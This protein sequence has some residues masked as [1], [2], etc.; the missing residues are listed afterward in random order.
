MQSTGSSELTPRSNRV[1][2]SSANQSDGS[3][4]TTGTGG[5]SGFKSM[6]ARKATVSGRQRRGSEAT[7]MRSNRRAPDE[8]FGPLAEGPAVGEAPVGWPST[9]NRQQSDRSRHGQP[10]VP[11][12]VSTYRCDTVLTAAGTAC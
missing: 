11:S 1:N 2:G 3:S 5:F 4:H 9:P 8:L 7:S 10:Q 6:L 12:K